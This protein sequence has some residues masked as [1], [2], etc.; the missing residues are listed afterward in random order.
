MPASHGTLFD[1]MLKEFEGAA[2]ILNL[3]PGLWQMLTHPK[4]QIIVSC[5]VQMDNGAIQ[6]FTGYRVQYN[7]TLGPYKGGIRY[8]QNVD[9]AEVVGLAALM[10][11]KN[12]VLGLPLGGAVDHR[13]QARR[14]G[15]LAR[16][17]R[18]REQTM[19]HGR[20]HNRC[21]SDCTLQPYR[22]IR[23]RNNSHR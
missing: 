7:S 4:R 21:T 8:H 20:H 17:G 2:R 16:L 1:G 15:G 18:E 9:L 3:D 14:V 23:Q 12:S 10:T 22:H 11:F 5:P 6:V 19:E 13:G